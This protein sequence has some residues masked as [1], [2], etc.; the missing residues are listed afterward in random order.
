MW[1]QGGPGTSSMFGL[2]EIN[3][4]FSAVY[5][6]DGSSTTAAP[7][8]HSWSTVANV[9]YVD[10]PVGTGFSHTSDDFAINQVQTSSFK[11]RVPNL[12]AKVVDIFSASKVM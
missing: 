10:N 1:L 5:T 4:P 2:F 11:L 6:E 9:L 7:N 8:P 3:G 12:S